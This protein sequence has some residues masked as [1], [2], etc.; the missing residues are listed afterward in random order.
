MSRIV[1][2][3]RRFLVEFGGGVASLVLVAACSSSEA[4]GD[5]PTGT[6]GA[7]AA[8]AETTTPATVGGS[9]GTDSAVEDGLNGVAWERVSFGF[10]SAYLLQRGNEVTVVDTGTGTTAEFESG[11]SALG[12]SWNNVANVILTHSHGDHIGGLQGVIDNAPAVKAF[13]GVGDL[14]AIAIGGFDADRLTGVSDGDE[15]FGLEVISTPGHT[16]GHIVVFDRASGLLVAGDA[17][18][19]SGGVITGPN[20][21]FTPDMVSAESSVAKILEGR[22]VT[23]ALVG[24]G[25]PVEG[26]AGDSL[27]DLVSSLN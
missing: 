12:A 3:R 20:P 14:D 23:T 21:D 11:L 18:N 26:T 19:T 25:D 24:H 8:G 16:P 7:E 17:I 2:S 13:A 15:V 4:S 1:K 5:G 10:V 9:A 22:S 6:T 27:A